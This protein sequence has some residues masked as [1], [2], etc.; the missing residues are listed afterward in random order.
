MQVNMLVHISGVLQFS[1]ISYPRSVLFFN[2][3]RGSTATLFAGMWTGPGLILNG[4]LARFY[5]NLYKMYKTQTF[6]RIRPLIL[7]LATG[8]EKQQ[9][10]KTSLHYRGVFEAKNCGK[11][12]KAIVLSSL[13][14][15]FQYISASCMN[16]SVGRHFS[17]FS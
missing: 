4:G 15:V 8:S 7:P 5:C 11:K 12:Y 13:L 10:K 9:V 14:F 1:I 2:G 3:K 6:P 17:L 16:Y